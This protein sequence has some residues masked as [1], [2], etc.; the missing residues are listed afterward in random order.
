M[1][2]L[3]WIVDSIVQDVPRNLDACEECRETDCSQGRFE[4]C[5]KR[6]ESMRLAEKSKEEVE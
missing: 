6:K 5:T 1:K 3:N 2:F 4:D